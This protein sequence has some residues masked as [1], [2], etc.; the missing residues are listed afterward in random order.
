M[1]L[2]L[3]Y[4]W[5]QKEEV[6]YLD[7]HLINSKMKIIRD[8]RDLDYLQNTKSFMKQIAECDVAVLVISDNYLKSKNCLFEVINLFNVDI[9][10]KKIVPILMDDVKISSPND[11]LLYIKYWEEQIKK[12]NLA[13]KN[14]LDSMSFISNLTEELEIYEKIRSGLDQFFNFLVNLLYFKYSEIK[15]DKFYALTCELGIDKFVN[16]KKELK[17]SWYE[18]IVGTIA[19]IGLNDNYQSRVINIYKLLLSLSNGNNSDLRNMMIHLDYVCHDLASYFTKKTK[20]ECGVSIRMFSFEGSDNEVKIQTLARD[21]LFDNYIKHPSSESLTTSIF[22]NSD[23]QSVFEDF[24][25]KKPF[26]ISHDLS[27]ESAF[28]SAELNPYLDFFKSST[29][30]QNFYRKANWPLPYLSMVASPIASKSR[31]EKAL[32]GILTVYS[33]KTNVFKSEF[34]IQLIN[35]IGNQLYFPFANLKRDRPQRKTK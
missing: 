4:S 26:F 16:D 10:K 14:N 20:S 31:K 25:K 21:K 32:V 3:S 13:I 19:N 8:I 23:L 6:D 18:S 30:L 9:S 1:K 27:K 24:N 34:D 11:R 12:L 22:E 15:K 7:N 29:K 17:N 35:D 28:K 5:A 2:F 33:N